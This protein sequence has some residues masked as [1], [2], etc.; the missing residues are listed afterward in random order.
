MSIFYCK[1]QQG[2]KVQYN[3]LKKEQGVIYK[4]APLADTKEEREDIRPKFSDD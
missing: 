2:K 3:R 4:F 1:S